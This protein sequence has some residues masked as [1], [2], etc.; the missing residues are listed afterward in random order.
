V[1]I[2]LRDHSLNSSEYRQDVGLLDHTV[3]FQKGYI[4]L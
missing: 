2:F 4:I 3:V 1:Q